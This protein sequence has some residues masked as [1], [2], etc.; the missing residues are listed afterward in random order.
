M[1]IPFEGENTKLQVDGSKEDCA[2]HNISSRGLWSP[3]ER[4][5]Y[6]GQVHLKVRK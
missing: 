2:H 1:L 5:F 6:D 3:F 4:T